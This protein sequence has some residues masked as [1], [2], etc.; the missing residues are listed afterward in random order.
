MLADGLGPEDMAAYA[1][2]QHRWARGCLSSIGT[3]LRARI[4]WRLRAHYLLSAMYFLSG[5]TLLAYMAFPVIRIATGAQPLAGATADQFLLHFAPYFG[6][7]LWMVARAGGGSYRFCAYALQAA[8]A[9]IHVHASLQT[10]TRRRGR[11]VVTPKEGASGRQPR[12]V[13]VPLAIV[14]ILLGAVAYGLAR[15]QGPATLNNVAFAG[16]H[17]CVLLSGAWPALKGTRPVQGI[18]CRGRDRSRSRA[19]EGRMRQAARLRRALLAVV[20]GLAFAA[21]ADAGSSAGDDDRAQRPHVPADVRAAVDAFYR[22]A[23][24]PNGRVTRRDQGAT[25]SARA[26]RTRC[27][28][29][30]RSATSGASRASGAGPAGTCCST[31]ARSPGGGPAGA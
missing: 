17:V 10:L 29:R 26:R 31:T 14:A 27:C 1:G 16:L 5:W 22:R 9:W 13:A 15:D 11:F 25:P 24:L 21:G 30:S 18:A 4:P 28:W 12:A 3:V 8:S 23:L 2:Q 7:A 6:L 19:G 20:A